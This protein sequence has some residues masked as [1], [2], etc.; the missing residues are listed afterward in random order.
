MWFSTSSE[1]SFKPTY[2]MHTFI[3]ID[4]TSY[5]ITSNDK[6]FFHVH[7]LHTVFMEKDP[8][9]PP[10]RRRRAGGSVEDVGG[11]ASV[12]VGSD[13]AVWRMVAKMTVYSIG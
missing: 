11:D 10:N 2:Y 7:V 12:E 1:H 9:G 13:E 8:A 4:I 3:H 5:D 6:T